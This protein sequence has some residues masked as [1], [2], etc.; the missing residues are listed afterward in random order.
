MPDIIIDPEFAALIP[1]HKAAERALLEQSL[2]AEGCRDALVVWA[3]HNI[4]LDGHHRLELC[5]EHGIAYRIVE[6]EFNCREDAGIWM[7][8][9]QRAR[10]N[11]EPLRHHPAGREAS[12]IRQTQSP[13]ATGHAH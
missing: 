7:C 4:L 1:P 2:K 10:R 13:S 9:N 11:L 5:R 12:R 6:R 8:N 3:R